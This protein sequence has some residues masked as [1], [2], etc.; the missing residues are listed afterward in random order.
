MFTINSYNQYNINWNPVNF[1]VVGD[2]FN[3][4]KTKYQFSNGLSFNS[5]AFLSGYHDV[6]FNNKSG[7]ILSKLLNNEDIIED[8][9]MPSVVSNLSSIKT[10]VSDYNK[11]LFNLYYISPGVSGLNANATNKDKI[12]NTLNFVF[13]NDKVYI[14][15]YQNLVL[16]VST[17]GENGLFFQEKD[18]ALDS[19]QYFDYLIY[20]NTICLFASENLYPKYTAIITESLNTG[21]LILQNY[22]PINNSQLPGNAI[23][24]IV[25]Y[26]NDPIEY[27]SVKNSF[28]VK[29]KSDPTLN[30]N[31]LIFSQTNSNYNQNYLGIFPYENLNTDG[32][33]DFYFHGLK[34]YQTT[35]YNYNNIDYVN[36][37]NQQRIYYKINAGTNQ[38]NGTD[39]VYL[40]Y[41]TNTIAIEIKP[42]QSTNF[43]LSPTSDVV[44]LSAAGFIENGASGGSYPVVSDR[45]YTSSKSNFGDIIEISNILNVNNDF[46]SHFLCSWLEGNKS[47]GQKVWYDRYYNPAYYSMDQALSASK[48]V[49]NQ[50]LSSNL[51]F[52]YDVPSKLVLTPGVFYQYYHVGNEDSKNFIDTLNYKYNNGIVNSNILNI[53]SWNVALN[54]SSYYNNNTLTFGNSTNYLN[55]Y[56]DMDG[57]N[58]AIIQANNTLLES[59]N[60]TVSL[61]LKSNDWANLNGYQIFGNYYNSGF[62]LINE[63]STIV[64]L[65]TVI[66]NGTGQIYNFNCRFGETSNINS[67]ITNAVIVQRLSDLSY[68]V[69]DQGNKQA[70]KYDVSN[71]NIGMIDLSSLTTIDQV[72]TDGAENLYIYDNTSKAYIISDSSGNIIGGSSA[73]QYSNRIEIGPFV[74]STG[75]I[76]Y[77]NQNVL[78]YDGLNGPAVVGNASVIDN[79]GDLWQVIGVNLYKNQNVV[80]TVGSSIQV[81]C[82]NYNNI[83]VISNDDSFTKLDSQ[84]N[85]I[86][87]NKFSKTNI[88][89]ETNCILPD[90]KPNPLNDLQILDE[91]LP[92]LSKDKGTYIL[93]LEDYQELLVTPPNYPPIKIK[94]PVRP[95]VRVV[96]FINLPITNQNN[97]TLT[98]ICGVSAIEY[99]QM[100]VVDLYDN[101]A[102][103][104]SQQGQLVSKLNLEILLESNDIAAFSTGGDFTGYQNVRKFKNLKN[105]TLSWKFQ[106][107][108]DSG[109]HTSNILTKDVSNL[110]SGWHN[111]VFVFDTDKSI[112]KYFIDTVLVDILQLQP[113]THIDY[114]YRTSYI[115][116]ATTI[117]NTILN[118]FLNIYDGY[119]YM[120]G[121]GDLKIYNIPLSNGDVE[122]LYYSST[123]APNI[124][125]L[126]WNMPIGYRN[127]IEEI[128]EWFQFQLPTNKSKYYNINIH[129]FDVDDNIKANLELAIKN[130]IGKLSP[131]HTVLNQINFK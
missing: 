71:S 128:S 70:L 58:Y 51:P 108:D 105:T 87:R 95:R 11:Y 91:E 64:P 48:L 121:F 104:I 116:G 72:E 32:T 21:N 61:W 111:F 4:K 114:V 18:T 78:I 122:Q 45:L 69:F 83:W 80:A 53:T 102:Y 94:R 118:N 97:S 19:N 88:P 35:E 41:Q 123:F 34:N 29:Y 8:A 110:S 30:P 59:D 82:D 49:Y 24:N 1:K 90:T 106:T 38:K 124:N 101:Q 25:S 103:I 68:W 117:K 2:H 40:T 23:L 85:I 126:Y 73:S 60:L 127:Y 109:N 37:N 107:Y 39:K 28:L 20:Q 86:F 74:D 96:D 17:F 52:V 56:W 46:D 55:D 92:F 115:I 66:N 43:Y 84:G 9:A 27:N 7:L 3:L 112:A 15:N 75:V 89:I 12:D 13:E 67:T 54:D 131:A 42:N 31:S 63:S 93:T 10:L 62:G 36:S 47:N 44:Y 79:N 33:Y 26:K 98:S 130:I 6:S 57:S 81:T 129:N 14:Q 5:Y 76:S 77:Q 113:N 125:S 65:M 119:R 22:T 120:G 50:Y 16:T 100:V 99:D